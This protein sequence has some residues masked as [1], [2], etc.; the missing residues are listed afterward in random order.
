MTGVQVK[1]TVHL[2]KV[3]EDFFEKTVV[4]WR[5]AH[6]GAADR[7]SF[8][9]GSLILGLGGEMELVPRHREAQVRELLTFSPVVTVEGARQVGKATLAQVTTA[10][11]AAVSVTMDD[12][13]T[14]R[15]AHDDPVGFL[16]QAG[17]QR[18]II[19][20]IQRAPE[21][22]LALKLV[23]DQDRRPGRFLLT[24]SAN[25]LRVPGAEDSPAGRAITTRLEPFSQGEIELFRHDWVTAV[26]SLDRMLPP[27]DRS[28]L[29][30]RS[31]VVGSQPC[32]SCPSR[33][34]QH[35]CART[36][37]GVVERDSVDLGNLPVGSVAKAPTFHRCYSR[38]RAEQGATRRAVVDL[39]RNTITRYLDVLEVLFLIRTVPA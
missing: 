21:L 39:S 9:G 16:V 27:G 23:V 35:G 6:P 33:L 5:I 4:T 38:G 34:G 37:T 26:C 3:D 15:L 31:Y 25:V 1:R 12:D 36:Q 32:R 2:V 11:A 10:D 28:D 20:E 7:S 30:D 22:V 17:E 18:L 29:V 13:L 8:L 19:D 24:G 14:R